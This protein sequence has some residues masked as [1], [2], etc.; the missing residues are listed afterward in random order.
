MEYIYVVLHD[1]FNANGEWVTDVVQAFR[2]RDVAEHDVEQ[3]V[4]NLLHAGL[5]AYWSAGEGEDGVLGAGRECVIAS[6]AMG[7]R[8]HWFRMRVVR[9]EL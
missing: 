1:H 6:V 2:H 8:K 5:R 7:E 4:E 3:N 9:M